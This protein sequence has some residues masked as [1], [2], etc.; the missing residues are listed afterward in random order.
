MAINVGQDLFGIGL[1]RGQKIN[2]A[3]L[4]GVGY[5]TFSLSTGMAMVGFQAKRAGRGGFVSAVVGQT[6]AAA[7][8]IPLAGFAAAGLCLIP[9]VGPVAAAAVGGLLSDYAELRI[10]TQ[11]V[12]AVRYFT[13]T[14][15]RIRHLEMGGSYKDSELA[16]RQRFFAI[17]D[18]NA[19]M[20]P[21]RRYLGQ[22]ASF[23]HR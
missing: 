14:A 22:E 10:G 23:L 7:V 1:T 19:T 15:K 4:G 5:G 16:Q 8:G 18:M 17:H 9:G 2:K 12:K 13:D 6:A 20:I 11:F 3:W 21:N